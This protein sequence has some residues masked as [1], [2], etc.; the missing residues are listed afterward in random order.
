VEDKEVFP[1]RGTGLGLQKESLFSFHHPAG[2]TYY[3]GLF[4]ILRVLFV[5]LGGLKASLGG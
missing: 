5:V 1:F 2:K 4:D 3:W